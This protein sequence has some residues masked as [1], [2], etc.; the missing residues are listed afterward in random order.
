M[1]I[2]TLLA[3]AVAA[4][5][6]VG[7]A[8]AQDVAITGGRVL[9]GTSV[10]ENGTVVVRNGRV[11]SVG[12]GAAPAGM[13]AIDARGKI[14]TPG[15]VAVDSG[16]GGSEVGSVRGSNDLSNSANTLSA[17]FDLSYGLDPWSFTLP[18]AR[19]G[20]VTRAVVTPQHAGS[21]GGHSH[22][23]SDFAGAGHGGYQSPGLF[24]GQAAVI[25]L[26]GADILVK[27]RVAMVAPFGEAGKGVAGGARGAE[28][29]LF[30]ETLAEVRLYARNKAAYD[31]AALRDLSLSRADLEALIPV[32]NGSMPLIVSV[33]RASDIQQ[34]LRLAREEGVKV[35]LDGAA[36]GWL[37]A[38]EIAAAKVPVLLHPITNLPGNF[39]MRAARMQNAAALNAAGVVIAIKGNEG[40]THR[41]RDIRYNA[42]NAVSHGLP[43]AAAIQAITVNPARIF[44]FDGQFGELKPG[45]AGDV[46]VWSGDPLEPLSQPSAVFIDGVEQPLQA[47]NLLLRDRYRTGGEGA[48]P[49]AYP[50]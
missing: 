16:L 49:V 18:V 27:P 33:N 5:A 37:V 24:A 6:L 38:N 21:G 44:G 28:F 50:Q 8:A 19:L 11:V 17:A 40:S 13:R 25:K 39:E 26:G 20:G 4:L 1:R 3:G 36:E 23:D 10:I 42:G 22:D 35:I 41:A 9:T 48:M 12:T 29:V 47:R 43:F 30:K 14:V 32:A 34:V 15:F 45:A 31:R 7:P 46:V 2:Q